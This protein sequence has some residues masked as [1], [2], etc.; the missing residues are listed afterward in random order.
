MTVTGLVSE[1][2]DYLNKM[3]TNVGPRFIEFLCPDINKT[4]IYLLTYSME[5]SHAC[6]A[7]WFSAGQ[8]I[9]RILWK[10]MVHYLIYKRPPPV[11]ILS[12]I[13]SV[14]APISL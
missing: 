9:P 4:Y 1:R 8:E 3:D 14:H 13:N 12:Q 7:N 5:K 10:P 6:E 2:S 11:R